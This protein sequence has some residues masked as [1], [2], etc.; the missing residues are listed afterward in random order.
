MADEPEPQ[1]VTPL[2]FEATRPLCAPLQQG[3][4][5]VP[6]LPFNVAAVDLLDAYEE[7]F[8]SMTRRARDIAPAL[9]CNKP[10][11]PLPNPHNRP[12]QTSSAASSSTSRKKDKAKKTKQSEEELDDYEDVKKWGHSHFIIEMYYEH[13]ATGYNY[14]GMMVQLLICDYNGYLVGIRRVAYDQWSKWYY[15][16]DDFSLPFFL[17]DGA[18]KLPIEG[19]HKK[20]ALLGG[21]RTFVHIFEKLGYYP[22]TGDTVEME[23]AFLAAV[24]V[25]CEARR[26]VWI[27]MEVKERI[28][29][30]E[31]PRDLDC[32]IPGREIHKDYAWMDVK[33]WGIDSKLVLTSAQKGVYTPP[34]ADD[35]KAK[36]LVVIDKRSTFERLIA[37]GRESGH[38]GLI[39]R[40]DYVLAPEG[41]RV[42]MLLRKKKDQLGAKCRE[43][44]F[45]EVKE[46]EDDE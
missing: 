34:R 10:I 13:E 40:D 6:V 33:D 42:L 19:D 7:A 18:E 30:K 41:S 21:R 20:R 35:G 27:F 4:D 31:K 25:F 11:T 16:S 17:K 37:H 15:C 1:L 8:K 44:Y 23:K 24:L 12:R 5:D 32:T 29:R 9:Y 3:L 26:F 39:M 2:V 38:L 43:P 45:R 22:D 46:D 36:T 28:R 14:D